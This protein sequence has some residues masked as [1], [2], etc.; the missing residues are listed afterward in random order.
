M[1]QILF[2]IIAKLF[3][4]S[5]IGLQQLTLRYSAREAFVLLWVL[6]FQVLQSLSKL[7]YFLHWSQ[8]DVSFVAVM[9][10]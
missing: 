9:F 5:P 8:E 3:S 10:C 2:Y 7:D 4:I 6:F 1:Y